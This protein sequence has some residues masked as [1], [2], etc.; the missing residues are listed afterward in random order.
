MELSKARNQKFHAWV[1][2]C[3]NKI[4]DAGIKWWIDWGTLYGY[5]TI[6]DIHYLDVGFDIGYLSADKEKMLEIFNQQWFPNTSPISIMMPESTVDALYGRE[7]IYEEN[8]L[9]WFTAWD[10]TPSP[11]SSEYLLLECTKEEKTG[12]R[13]WVS[14]KNIFP[15]EKGKMQGIDVYLP[16]YRISLLNHRYG[17]MWNNEI[18]PCLKP[19]R[20]ANKET[21]FTGRLRP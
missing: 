16:A 6:R 8:D 3:L 17:P 20:R 2:E 7:P 14:T 11:D 4:N 15:L 18:P 12:Y 13:Q 19:K 21:Q 10:Y 5:T 9:C 1:T